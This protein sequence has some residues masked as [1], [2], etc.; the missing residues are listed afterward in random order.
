MWALWFA[1]S[2]GLETAAPLAAGSEP[3]EDTATEV[4]STEPAS[5]PDRSA[6]RTCVSTATA[7]RDGAFDSETVSTYNA[8]GWIARVEAT[9][10][11]T[12]F[13]A[14]NP[15]GVSERTE[16]DLGPDGVVDF[17]FT[18]TYDA[19]WLPVEQVVDADGDGLPDE[20]WSWT[21]ADWRAVGALVYE[22][23]DGV[24]D[25][26]WT[27]A[28]DDLGRIVD[29]AGDRGLDGSVDDRY[30]RAWDVGG[31]TWEEE[32][33]AYGAHVST[34]R[35]LE[36]EGG[37]LLSFQNDTGASDL[38]YVVT[39]IWRYDGATGPASSG[40]VVYEADAYGYEAALAWSY[41]E[42]GREIAYDA[43]YA[44]TSGIPGFA[45]RVD[46]SWVCPPAR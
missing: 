29:Q 46:T 1:C 32:H 37:R 43:V 13:E 21:F 39:Q 38:P 23:A 15:W 25:V 22:G 19:D 41:D 36:D 5:P 18:A 11:L 7:T 31:W 27:Y 14:D 40:D 35:T 3:A 4:V 16:I 30:V 20:V 10:S 6:S 12:T 34:Q 24:I 44:Y 9:S 2:P 8:S 17:R 42:S 28:Y 33:V 45:W 26:A